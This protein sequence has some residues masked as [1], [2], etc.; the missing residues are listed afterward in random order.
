[1]LTR[2]EQEKNKCDYVIRRDPRKIRCMIRKK[3]VVANVKKEK[4]AEYN[5]HQP[6]TGKQSNYHP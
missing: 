5:E 3:S 4:K 1:M 2:Y 6:K